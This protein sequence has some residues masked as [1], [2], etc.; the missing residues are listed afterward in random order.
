MDLDIDNLDL[1]SQTITENSDSI[2]V[3][4]FKLAIKKNT[5]FKKRALRECLQNHLF[6]QTLMTDNFTRHLEKAGDF[7][8]A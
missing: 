4:I 1:N 5:T 7:L 8:T 2:H 3:R 6:L